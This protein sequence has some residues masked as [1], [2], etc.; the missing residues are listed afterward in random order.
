[1]PHGRRF[2]LPAWTSFSS[3]IRAA[4]PSGAGFLIFGK[5]AGRD[6]TQRENMQEYKI[7]GVGLPR[8]YGAVLLLTCHTQFCSV[9]GYP[10]NRIESGLSLCY[11]LLR[12]LVPI[13][14]G[15]VVGTLGR[16]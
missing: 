2:L 1:M 4:V 14:F 16:T 15:D 7:E 5:A 13:E 3:G 8:Q 11:C 6:E 10:S 9:E 12:R